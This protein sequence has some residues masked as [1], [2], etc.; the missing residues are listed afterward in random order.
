MSRAQIWAQRSKRCRT[1]TPQ[2]ALAFALTGLWLTAGG[3][4]RSARCDCSNV[5]DFLQVLD[6][7]LEMDPADW[8]VVRRDTLFET[9]RPA[10]F[11]CG[12]E[13]PIDVVVRRKRSDALPS[14]E[15]P[16]KVS[17]KIDFDDRV[18]D[19][20]WHSHRKLSL[21]SGVIRAALPGALLREGIAWEILRRSGTVSGAATWVR[22]HLNGQLLGVYTRVEEID[23][24][25][26]RRR[27]DEDEGFLYKFDTIEP[28]VGMHRRLTRR[29]ETD[30]YYDALCWEPFDAFCAPPE[31]AFGSLRQHLDVRQYLHVTTVNALL[32]N[33]DG[34]LEVVQNYFFYDTERP[35]VY[36]SWDLDLTLLPD[37]AETPPHSTE[38]DRKLFEAAPGLR[39]IWDRELLR[40]ATDTMADANIDRL[41]DDVAAAVG[42]AVKAD[43]YHHLDGGFD[44]ELERIR[45]WLKAR[46]A[47]LR[48]SL[49]PAAP[50]SLVIN[51]VLAVNHDTNR[52]GADE[53]DDWVEILNRSAEP[54]PLAGL[55]LS[56][57][58][59]EPLRFALPDV[60]LSPGERLLIWCDNDLEQ[61]PDHASFQLDGDGEAIGLYEE[62]DGIVRVH[63]FLRFG[64]QSADVSI[65]RSP[66]GDP[67]VVPLPCP[68]SGR[69]NTGSCGQPKF[70]RGDSDGSG[71]VNIADAIYILGALFLGGPA[72][73]CP[74]SADADGSAAVNV[75]DPIYLLTH[76]F[77]SG[78]PP[79]EPYPDCGLG[80]SPGDATLGCAAP[81]AVCE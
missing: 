48:S 28:D 17:L 62:V 60:V 76:L 16:I 26:L 61:G 5:D 37:R 50:S 66:D 78:P 72:L 35:R 13:A 33:I 53:T 47:F 52:D 43:P 18:E 10:R 23:K 31:D 3:A 2:A 4:L 25:F 1:S 6:L 46:T 80:T 59:A 57:D 54:A 27:L 42:P 38:V 20:E 22:L 70:L 9:E 40:L 41:L 64:P 71:T 15:D 24:S 73:E 68:T 79:Q 34:L 30:P 81:P 56:D 45:T 55:F 65:G 44:A 58:P 14:S 8:D 12:D 36:F 69:E 21:E 39:P 74:A 63:D 77:A 75:T 19:G 7:H 67:R 51:E 29:D 49:P 32:G 11:H